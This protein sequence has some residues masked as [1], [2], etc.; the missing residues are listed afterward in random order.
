VTQV[1]ALILAAGSATR[2]GR[3]KQLLDWHGIP[4][5]RH[6]AETALAST[7]SQVVVVLGH[8]ADDVQ[9]ALAGLRLRLAINPDHAEGQSTSFKAGLAALA[10]E[11]RAVIVL[12]AD[13]PG[14]ES[15]TIDALISAWR[16]TGALIV[17]ARYRSSPSHPVLFDLRLLSELTSVV[18]DEGAR[19]VLTIHRPETVFVDIDH[20][21]P[22]DIDTDA[23]YQRAL[24]GE[25]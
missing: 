16:Q 10:A 3:P 14:V 24:A 25:P 5:V 1:S 13:Q 21:V 22:P 19:S 9:D 6:I 12:L 8:A 4:L 23:D 7:A 15:S 17:R 18:G 20:S 11:S 2:L